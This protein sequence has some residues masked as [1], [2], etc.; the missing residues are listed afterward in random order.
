MPTNFVDIENEFSEIA[1]E[2]GHLENRLTRLDYQNPPAD[3]QDEWEATLICASAAE[4]IYS[5]CERVMARLA[6]DLDGAAVSHSEGWHSALLRRIANPYPGIR[7]PIISPE[8]LAILD[9]LRSFRHRER[10]SYGIHLNFEIVIER[11]GEAVVGF[12][13]FRAEVTHFLDTRN[14]TTQPPAATP[15][16]Q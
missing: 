13:K 14:S 8:C 16:T 6:A 10:N 4:K 11:A 3:P 2:V 15:G 7:G 5:G 12:A 1:I 9:K